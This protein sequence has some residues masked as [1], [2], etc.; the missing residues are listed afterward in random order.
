MRSQL[1]SLKK[2]DR[3]LPFTMLAVPFYQEKGASKRT[4]DLRELFGLTSTPD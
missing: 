1:I 4:R 3:D 2:I